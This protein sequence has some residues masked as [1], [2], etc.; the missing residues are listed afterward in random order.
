MMH[1]WNGF[2]MKIWVGYSYFPSWSV[3]DTG[4]VH[5]IDTVI[6][7]ILSGVRDPCFK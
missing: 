2:L 4:I 7:N 3:I 5:V 1:S 6:D